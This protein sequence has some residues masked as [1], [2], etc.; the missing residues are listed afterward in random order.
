MNAEAFLAD[1]V[2]N[3][4]DDTPRLAF[5]DWLEEQGDEAS[6]ARAEFI[7]SQ[8]DRAR[9]D[10][11]VPCDL[12]PREEKLVR[13]YEKPWRRTWKRRWTF[14][15]DELRYRRGFVTEV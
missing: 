8:I 11:L 5:A 4:Q 12:T 10:P 2:E 7:R 1:V 3:P 6:A 9:R 14:Q 15:L 13:K